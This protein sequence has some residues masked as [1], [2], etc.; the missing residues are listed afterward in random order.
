MKVKAA[1]VVVSGEEPELRL[2]SRALDCAYADRYRVLGASS[3]A[4]ALGMLRR[5]PPGVA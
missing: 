2:L 5:R 1:V 3:S 4:E